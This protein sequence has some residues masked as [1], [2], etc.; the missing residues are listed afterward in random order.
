M[1]L[2]NKLGTTVADTQTSKK[3]TQ[4]VSGSSASSELPASIVSG[5]AAAAAAAAAGISGLTN[6]PN[7]DAV[8]KAQELA[9]KM[10]FRQDPQFAPVIN[11]FPGTSSELAV[12]QRPA[13]APVLRLD[14]QGREID[15]HGNVISI[16]KPSS[17][18][19]LKVKLL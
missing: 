6:I 4:P 1:Q 10:G 19:T 2:N 7:L 12:S 13:K 5:M 8:K 3:E 18:S 17:L 9:A 14:A 11:M 15:E 16:T